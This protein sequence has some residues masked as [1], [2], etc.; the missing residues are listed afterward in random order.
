MVIVQNKNNK[1]LEAKINSLEIILNNVGGYIFTKDLAGRYTYVNDL[2]TELFQ[3]DRDDIIG[4]DDSH[5][6]DLNISDEIKQN[7]LKVMQQGI[8]IETEELIFIKALGGLRTCKTIK[9]PL[10]DAQGKIIGMSGISTDLS[11]RKKLEV[12]VE[13]QKQFLDIILDNVDAFIYMKDSTRHFRYVNNKVAEMFGLPIKDIVGKLD[14]DVIPKAFADHFWESD[15]LVFEKN[16]KQTIEEEIADTDGKKRHY[17]STKIPYQ[18]KD[19]S[20]VLIGFSTEVTELYELKERFKKQATI[21]SLTGLHNR[22]YFLESAEREFHRAKRHQLPFSIITIDI[23]RFKLIN[24]TYGHPVGDLVLVNVCK[25]I[26]P[27][28]RAEDVLA[29]IGGEEFSILLP[30]TTI[31]RARL[32]AHRICQFQSDNAMTGNWPGEINA[33]ISVGVTCM[34]SSDNSFQELFSRS[35]KALYKAKDTGKN[36]VTFLE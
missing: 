14:S 10:F 22:R 15:R 13:E 7:D 6:F 3:C 12:L 25:N 8:T 24:D 4:K 35:D 2:V 16:E 30:N 34:K 28:I 29:R 23:D 11:E 36:R 27:S 20:H 26:L 21:D 9:T 18:F 5:F 1:E 33:T 32:V 17:I 19:C 31:E